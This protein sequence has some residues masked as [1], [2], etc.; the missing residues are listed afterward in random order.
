MRTL[1]V[2]HSGAAAPAS[3]SRSPGANTLGLCARLFGPKSSSPGSGLLEKQKPQRLVRV[4]T[5]VNGGEGGIRTPGT[6]FNQYG[7]LAN[8]C[9]QPL[10]HLSAELIFEIRKAV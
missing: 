1:R 2:A 8:H 3:K 10:G 4:L 7:G 9:L 6:G 5:K